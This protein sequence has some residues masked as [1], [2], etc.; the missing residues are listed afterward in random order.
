[1][2]SPVLLYIIVNR[3]A[4]E[5]SR[6]LDSINE[7]NRQFTAIYNLADVVQ[8]PPYPQQMITRKPINILAALQMDWAEKHRISLVE[9]ENA[10]FFIVADEKS[11]SSDIPPTVKV[12][13]LVGR[14]D[15]TSTQYECFRCAVPDAIGI[16]NAINGGQHGWDEFMALAQSNGGTLPRLS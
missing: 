8:F 14:P 3:P 9:H 2:V 1:M 6:M 5:M 12:V 15:S 11:F 16:F 10:A 13:Y 7:P 4:F